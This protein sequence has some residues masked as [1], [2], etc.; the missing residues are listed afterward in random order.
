VRRA[1][2]HRLRLR[3]NC[4]AA[5]LSPAAAPTATSM[6]AAPG[7]LETV[8]PSV[9]DGLSAETV[10]LSVALRKLVESREAHGS[11]ASS[12]MAHDVLTALRCIRGGISDL[13]AATG[14]PVL[15]ADQQACLQD[16]ARGASAGS[17]DRFLTPILRALCVPPCEGADPFRRVLVRRDGLRWLSGPSAA[18]GSDAALTSDLVLSWHP[19]VEYRAACGSPRQAAG[20]AEDGCDFE[21][22]A[23]AGIEGGGH[24]FGT[25]AGDPLQR[26]GCV[27]GL[28]KANR[29]GRVAGLF[30]ANRTGCVA[31]PLVD[32]R[33]EELD[34]ADFGELCAD[35]KRINGFCCGMMFDA[36][37]FWLYRAY[38]YPHSLVKGEWTAGGSADAIR[39]HFAAVPEPALLVLLRALL[40]AVDKPLCFR[41]GRAYLCPDASGHLFAVGDARRPL[42]LK[43]IAVENHHS[44]VSGEFHRLAAAAARCSAV[45]PPVPGS[46]HEFRGLGA[47]GKVNGGG[48]LLQRVGRPFV[49][50]SKALCAAAFASLAKL[51][52]H[53]IT[54][55]DAGVLSLMLVDEQP[56]W[57]NVR[58]SELSVHAPADSLARADVAALARSMLSGWTPDPFPDAVR[59]AV[60][61]YYAT[62]PDTIHAVADAVRA[63]WVAALV[64]GAAF[65]CE[66]RAKAGAG[67]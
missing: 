57:I 61:R 31:G 9:V 66:L 5:Y 64:D 45:V 58:A 4:R 24:P 23:G 50:D 46:L 14:E 44:H 16:I 13:A 10:H 21:T 28:F 39:A 63:A 11:P 67:Y 38:F 27:A 55:G 60:T 56:M 19:F 8:A 43:V 42:A 37:V 48:F 62:C 12:A 35:H 26:A 1:A 25:L 52:R 49:W 18:S 3:P 36:T 7:A 53:G 2:T 20:A 30:K 29:T 59:D 54:H 41:Q 51:H 65:V 34:P 40:P 32:D 15:S 33:T 17:V 22:L 47:D 6:S